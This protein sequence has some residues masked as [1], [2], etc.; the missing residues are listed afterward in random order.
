MVYSNG[1]ADGLVC[2]SIPTGIRPN[3]PKSHGSLMGRLWVCLIPLPPLK[4]GKPIGRKYNGEF[5]ELNEFSAAA[6]RPRVC[7]TQQPV[8]VG[9][10]L[11][12]RRDLRQIRDLRQ[13]T[14]RQHPGRHT[15]TL[16]GCRNATA[17]QPPTKKGDPKAAFSVLD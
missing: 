2:G 14:A 15:N 4:R 6:D 5:R 8:T 16:R 12:Q 10:D 1:L 7:K 11:R 9:R 3:P 17:L 13:H